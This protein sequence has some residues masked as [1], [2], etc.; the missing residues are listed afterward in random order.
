LRYIPWRE[1][2]CLRRDLQVIVGPLATAG[3]FPRSVAELAAA[4]GAS[5]EIG[6]AEPRT[7]WGL[8]HVQEASGRQ[9]AGPT[10]EGITTMKLTTATLVTVIGGALVLSTAS[11]SSAASQQG[12]AQTASQHV[13]GQRAS[14][15]RSSQ[16]AK[17]VR[18]SLT[19]SSA[20][21]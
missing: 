2:R 5:P 4:I 3:G 13:A 6:R 1:N 8:R 19:P 17:H 16:Q 7:V 21:L 20:A 9:A 11:L 15:V 10:I 12:H 14:Q 18:L